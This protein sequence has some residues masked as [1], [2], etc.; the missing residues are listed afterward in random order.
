MRRVPL[1]RMRGGADE[2][3]STPTV[4]PRQRQ[5]PTPASTP[6]I[7][8]LAPEPSSTPASTPPPAPEPTPSSPPPAKPTPQREMFTYVRCL[9]DD[10]CVQDSS[11]YVRYC[12]LLKDKC[13]CF[14]LD[15]TNIL[16]KDVPFVSRKLMIGLDEPI[17]DYAPKTEQ[18]LPALG[19]SSSPPPPPVEEPKSIWEKYW[20]PIVLGVFGGIILLICIVATIYYFATRKSSGSSVPM[21]DYS[22]A[23]YIPS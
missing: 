19:P 11:K 22:T 14:A 21:S 1:Y 18:L 17:V 15:G 5:A 7:P 6:T 3:A 9:S 4:D 12:N 8:P 20:I 16:C 23:S 10:D 13:A 2:P